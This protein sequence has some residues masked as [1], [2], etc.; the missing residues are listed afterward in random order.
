MIPSLIKTLE[1][2]SMP[3]KQQL[4]GLR[5]IKD[6]LAESHKLKYGDKKVIEHV[7]TQADL[8]KHMK[9]QKIVEVEA[10]IK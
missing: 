5:L 10:E 6:I 3:T 9:K 8:I 2:G 7:V 4:D 1:S